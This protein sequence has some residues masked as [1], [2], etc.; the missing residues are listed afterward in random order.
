[1]TLTDVADNCVVAG[2]AVRDSVWLQQLRFN[3]VR[4]NTRRLSFEIVCGT[5]GSLGDL[6][7]VLD[8]RYRSPDVQPS[9]LVDGE[10][11]GV[12]ATD[13][14]RLNG[15]AA[16]SYQ[17]ELRGLDPFCRADAWTE[18]IVGGESAVVTP[19]VV[20]AVPDVVPG[21]VTFQATT[22][23]DGD[24]VNG[25]GVVRDGAA[26]A[27]LPVDGTATVT[28]FAASQPTVLQVTDIAGNCQAQGPN[29]QVITLDAARTPVNVPFA[30][31]CSAAR[32]DT[33]IGEIDAT[34][35]PTSAAT[36]VTSDGTT[37][38]VNGPKTAELARLTGT[39]VRVWGR[40]S[41]TGIDVHGYDLRSQLGADR[42]LGIVLQRSD[43]LWL[44][45][46][47]GV[48]LVNPPAGLAAQSGNLLWVMGHEVEGGVQATVYGVIRGG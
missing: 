7:V 28:G 10:I 38:A 14:V 4:D 35:W 24:D 26:A 31:V 1:V 45:G 19:F 43:G 12:F 42:W 34:S 11:A 33:L 46:E 25:Y 29:P 40:V 3:P 44:F 48:R 21:T 39:P 30:V 9:L 32:A 6:G 16:G 17:L 8:A 2:G 20:C 18:T 13:T 22:T 41:A 36:L 27:R 5:A 23:G 47:E 37:L 15:L